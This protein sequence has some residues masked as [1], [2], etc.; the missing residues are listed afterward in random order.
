LCTSTSTA[1]QDDPGE[2]T[3]PEASG[4]P[5]ASDRAGPDGEYEDSAPSKGPKHELAEERTDWAKERTLLAKQRTFAAW[6]RTG[7]AAAGGGFAAAEFL[8]EIEP[9]WMVIT[10][11][12][13]LVLAGAVIFVIAFLGYRDTFRKLQHE[14]VA[15]IPPW[16]IGGVTLAMLLGALLLLYSVVGG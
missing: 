4:E 9:Q 8:G 14:G 16:V 13:L 12:A 15:G 2:D 5:K 10:A 1:D 11:S 3:R 7:L 6:L